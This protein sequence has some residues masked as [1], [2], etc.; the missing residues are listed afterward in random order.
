M[1]AVIGMLAGR[2]PLDLLGPL[3]AADVRS[4]VCVQP[5]TPRALEAQIV[6]KVADELGMTSSVAGSI[7]EGVD[8]A[9]EQ[10]G[11]DGMV[12]ATGSL[13]VVGPARQRLLERLASGR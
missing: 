12:L 4:V 6:A 2:D 8:R 10:A 1:V 9:L 13:Y 7:E 3:L 5:D 11:G